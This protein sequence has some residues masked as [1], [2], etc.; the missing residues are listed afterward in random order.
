CVFFAD[1]R[2]FLSCGYDRQVKAWDTETGECVGHYGTPELP[3][4]VASTSLESFV[5]GG[6]NG[7]IRQWD[8]RVKQSVLEYS[9]HRDSVNALGPFGNRFVS[10][11][12]DRTVRVWECGVP[13]PLRT[14]SDPD[15]TSLPALAVSPDL[16][17]VACQ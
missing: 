15:M 3:F 5:S 17:F 13:T 7:K 10:T 16:E 6:A 8:L 9:G 1:G 2:R 4:C 11:S 14:F 12:D